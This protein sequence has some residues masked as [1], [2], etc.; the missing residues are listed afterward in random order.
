MPP[1]F[2]EDGAGDLFEPV[3]VNLAKIRVML[4]ER[5]DEAKSASEKVALLQQR[6][7]I[8]ADKGATFAAGQVAEH[9]NLTATFY[10]LEGRVEQLEELVRDLEGQVA[11]RDTGRAR[12]PPMDQPPPTVPG[13]DEE[14]DAGFRL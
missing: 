5:R 1:N 8:A 7:K 2:R 9:L 14:A 10:K 12:R 3:T 4:Q 13:K 11:N 6:L